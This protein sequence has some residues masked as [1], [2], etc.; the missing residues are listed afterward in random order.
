[1]VDAFYPR[2]RGAPTAFPGGPRVDGDFLLRP[3]VDGEVPLA[4]AVRDERGRFHAD[5][6]AVGTLDA[7]VAELAKRRGVDL[8]GWRPDPDHRADGHETLRI[9]RSL[10]LFALGNGEWTPLT[11]LRRLGLKRDLGRGHWAIRGVADL[12]DGSPYEL[13]VEEAREFRREDLGSE[14]RH[15]RAEYGKETPFLFVACRG[16]LVRVLA[17]ARDVVDGGGGGGW[18]G[19]GGGGGWGGVSAAEL[20]GARLRT[21][22]VPADASFRPIL[23]RAHPLPDWW[24]R[25]LPGYSLAGKVRQP[26][27]GEGP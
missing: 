13:S 19:G 20:V 17:T 11:R 15:A 23:P 14:G 10:G 25:Y 6:V 24:M 1:M 7:V 3:L 9:P 5:P 2:H 26:V 12:P 21:S 27:R 4:V 16:A 22:S 8:E 18:G